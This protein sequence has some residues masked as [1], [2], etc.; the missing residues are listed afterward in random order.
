MRP[1]GEEQRHIAAKRHSALTG[2][3]RNKMTFCTN[4]ISAR[5]VSL[6]QKDSDRVI[7]SGVLASLTRLYG[8]IAACCLRFLKST[9]AEVAYSSDLIRRRVGLCE[10]LRLTSRPTTSFWSS[11]GHRLD[12]R[13][14]ILRVRLAT[15]REYD[16]GP[17]G[18]GGQHRSPLQIP[19]SLRRVL[20]QKSTDHHQNRSNNYVVR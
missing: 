14:R 13:L 8:T 6:P 20:R 18:Y 3:A 9:H 15:R 10:W 11:C 19:R 1:D 2:L 12:R 17:R 16:K 7:R 4:A 5:K